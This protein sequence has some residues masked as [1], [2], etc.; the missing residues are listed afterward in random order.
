MSEIVKFPLSVQQQLDRANAYERN[1]RPQEADDVR[2]QAMTELARTAPEL[3]AGLLLAAAGHRSLT[4]EDI[5]SSTQTTRH[6]KR[7]MGI[8]YASETTT[9]TDVQ[10]RQRKISL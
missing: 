1:N 2:M 10:T 5:A 9:V 4:V 7:C 8:R 3:V 6:E